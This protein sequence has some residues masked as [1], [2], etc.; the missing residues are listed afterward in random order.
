M[1]KQQSIFAIAIK[2]MVLKEHKDIF[3]EI[4][5]LYPE[6]KQFFN[7]LNTLT[8]KIGSLTFRKQGHY[9]RS[10]NQ[11]QLNKQYIFKEDTRVNRYLVKKNTPTDILKS[12][13][14]TM[15]HELLHVFFFDHG[16]DFKYYNNK[17]RKS[18]YKYEMFNKLLKAVYVMYE[19]YIP[20]PPKPL[21]KKTQRR[22]TYGISVYQ[23]ADGSLVF[24]G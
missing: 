14:I 5:R 17:F 15:Y 12:Y 24:R 6:K 10:K 8:F 13:F 9:N 7:N 3:L 22:S 2:N 18:I 11:I 16:S 4:V 23:D 19:V 20:K 1:D 21:K